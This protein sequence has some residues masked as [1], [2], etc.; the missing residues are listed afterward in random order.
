M[1]RI[2]ETPTSKMHPA[3]YSPGDRTASAVRRTATSPRP[4]ASGSG[5]SGVTHTWRWGISPGAPSPRPSRWSW[6]AGRCDPAIVRS[7]S[8][9]QRRT[10]FRRLRF[11]A[12][13]VGQ[14]PVF[15]AIRRR[16]AVC[17]SPFLVCW[18][19]PS[20]CVFQSMWQSGRNTWGERESA[21]KETV[22]ICGKLN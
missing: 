6:P 3:K 8:W 14:G 7:H 19:P 22:F 16:T 18:T 13:V 12:V 17:P 1:C 20:A 9:F 5:S 4:A 15:T 21:V 10:A 11:A 2:S